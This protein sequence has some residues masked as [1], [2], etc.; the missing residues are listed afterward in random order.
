MHIEKIIMSII[1]FVPKVI[2]EILY[3]LS[4]EVP[5]SE[6]DR[7][8]LNLL[9]EEVVTNAI[10]HGNQFDTR[11]KVHIILEH[12]NDIVTIRVRDEGQGFNYQ[13]LPDIKESNEKMNS[14]GRGIFLIKKIAD[15]VSFDETGSEV[16]IR[17]RI[18]SSNA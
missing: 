18:Q 5:L 1:E 2:M 7:L 15:D 12:D 6:Q 17:K 14:F 9:L 13:K 10:Q 3:E 11:R 16:C 8:D 4:K